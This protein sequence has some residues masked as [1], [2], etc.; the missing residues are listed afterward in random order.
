MS[1]YAILYAYSSWRNQFR[2]GASRKHEALQSFGIL[3]RYY[4][5]CN[6]RVNHIGISMVQDEKWI[7]VMSWMQQVAVG[8]TVPSL[9]AWALNSFPIQHRGLGMGFWATSFFLGQFVNP[10][11]VGF[12]NNLTGGIIPTVTTVGVICLVV[13]A[14]V[15]LPKSFMQK[16]KVK[17]L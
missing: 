2:P 6:H 5:D 17:T 1:D 11:V 16:A 8:L 3:L 7:V 14:I 13:A 4:S 10:L 15:W 9:V 12:I